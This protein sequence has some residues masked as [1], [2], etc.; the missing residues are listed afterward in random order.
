MRK[1]AD[2]I[3]ALA[4]LIGGGDGT[5]G[6]LWMALCQCV[7]TEVDPLFDLTGEPFEIVVMEGARRFGRKAQVGVSSLGD[8]KESFPDVEDTELPGIARLMQGGIV[9]N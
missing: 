4:R 6:P 9:C 7:A 2:Q 5:A 8:D 3:E 1:I